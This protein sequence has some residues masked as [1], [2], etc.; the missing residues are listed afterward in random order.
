MA[1]KLLS[2]HNDMK[3]AVVCFR[4][5][6]VVAFW[7]MTPCCSCLQTLTFGP[8]T[9]LHRVVTEKNRSYR[10]LVVLFSGDRVLLYWMILKTT[11][12]SAMFV[13]AVGLNMRPFKHGACKVSIRAGIGLLINLDDSLRFD[14]WTSL[15]VNCSR[16]CFKRL[17]DVFQTQQK[18]LL[19]FDRF[20]SVVL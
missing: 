9:K 5:I 14:L 15:T 19:Y 11:A 12:L 10:K 1:I 2:Q 7:V 16:I 17:L 8:P 4:K 18:L 6:Y 20:H 3:F 13:Q